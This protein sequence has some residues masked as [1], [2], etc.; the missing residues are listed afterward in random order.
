M[1]TKNFVIA[2]IVFAIVVVIIS[3][4]IQ[5]ISVSAGAAAS[6]TISSIP[7]V[8]LAEIISLAIAFYLALIA[9]GV[10]KIDT[11]K[12]LI[13]VGFYFIVLSLILIFTLLEFNTLSTTNPI[14]IILEI[15]INILLFYISLKIY[16]I[17]SKKR[18]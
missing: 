1:K 5:L 12:F 15:V 16:G 13:S 11:I 17:D 8:M 7:R 6:Y 14:L 10:K 2:F 4:I 9:Y 3:G 18:K